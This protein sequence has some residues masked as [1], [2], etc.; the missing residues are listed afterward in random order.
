[1]YFKLELTSTAGFNGAPENF[2]SEANMLEAKVCVARG[3][4]ANCGLYG[5]GDSGWLD[6]SSDIVAS[7][8]YC[9]FRPPMIR[10]LVFRTWGIV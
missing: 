1:M 5:V 6:E 7:G 3:E 4:R 10:I 9:S 2:L 8:I